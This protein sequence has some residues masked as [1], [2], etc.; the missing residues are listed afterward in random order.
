MPHELTTTPVV[1][2]LALTVLGIIGPIAVV[3]LFAGQ[4]SI[5]IKSLELREQDFYTTI[6]E[7]LGTLEKKVTSLREKAIAVKDEIRELRS[8]FR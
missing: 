3:C 2:E 1:I 8:A 5:K 6:R 4:I 7:D